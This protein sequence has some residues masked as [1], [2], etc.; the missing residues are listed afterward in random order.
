MDK[1]RRAI[2]DYIPCNEQ[3]AADRELLLRAIDR[4]ETPLSRENPFAHFSA[5]SWIVNPART[6]AL[7]AWHNIY[8]TWA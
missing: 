1:L 7:M 3:E 5:S 6:H 2:E 8:K 4:L